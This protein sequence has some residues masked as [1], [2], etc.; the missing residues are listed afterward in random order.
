MIDNKRNMCTGCTACY[1]VCPKKA[2]SMITDENGFKYPVIDEKKCV[3]CGLC[4]KVCPLNKNSNDSMNICYAAFN[5]NENDLLLGSSSGGIFELIA[6]KFLENNGI[7]IGAAFENNTLIH[8]AVIKIDDLE[9]LK[10]SKYVQS[11][12]NDIFSFIKNNISSNKILFIG[13]PCQ[14]AGL[15]SICK[16]DNLFTIDLFCHGVPSPLLF[17]KYIQDLEL[18][19]FKK[20]EKINFR[21]KKDGWQDYYTS[22]WFDDGT[23]VSESHNDNVYMNLFLTDMDLRESCYNC[24]FKLGNKY[25]DLTLGDYWGIQNVNSKMFNKNGVSAVIINN[26]KGLDLFESIKNELKY[27]KSDVESIIKYNKSL[28]DSPL[29]P[30]NRD[31]LFRNIN[32]YNI[33]EL[34]SK[35]KNKSIF[36][37]LI[38]KIIKK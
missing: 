2:I 20:I 36:E 28:I 5:K 7:V 12:L 17:S 33:F 24:K 26:V 15:K 37:R 29:I 18:K 10:G 27:E 21:D 22:I 6:N 11:D 23:S 30:K 31:K 25:S 3:K 9:Q 14:V 16:N 35:F 34:N 19:Y 32:K 38:N 8:K 13:T 4:E 1:T